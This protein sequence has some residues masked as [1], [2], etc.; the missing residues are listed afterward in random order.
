M[1]LSITSMYIWNYFLKYFSITVQNRRFYT[2]FY[3]LKPTD[4][5]RHLLAK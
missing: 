2:S 5:K 4:V 1:H 3:A